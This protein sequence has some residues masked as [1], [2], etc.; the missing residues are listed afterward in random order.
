MGEQRGKRNI[1]K[2]HTTMAS[3]NCNRTTCQLTK[4]CYKLHTTYPML[5]V[6]YGEEGSG[7]NII[8]FT[9]GQK[10]NDTPEWE[11]K[12]HFDVMQSCEPDVNG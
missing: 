2:F 6:L 11:A 5:Q 4:L 7:R 3:G 10:K 12:I 8:F 1:Y 9:V